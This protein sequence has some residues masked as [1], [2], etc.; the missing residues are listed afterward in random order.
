MA[1]RLANQKKRV[2]EWLG[3]KVITGSDGRYRF[4]DMPYT[5]PRGDNFWDENRK[6]DLLSWN[7]RV[8]RKHWPEIWDK[9]KQNPQERFEYSVHIDELLEIKRIDNVVTEANSEF[10]FKIHTTS[11]ELC[12][13]ALLRVIK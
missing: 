6:R 3:R 11:P 10:W 5:D 9:L 4:D 13:E 8:N 12:W 1:D 7:P 2:A